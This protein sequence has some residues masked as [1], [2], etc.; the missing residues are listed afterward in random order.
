M[1]LSEV[2]I[3]ENIMTIR[4]ENEKILQPRLRSTTLQKLR[5]CER[6]LADEKAKEQ[7]LR[8]AIDSVAKDLEK[9]EA[10][11]QECKK[12]LNNDRRKMER[13]NHQEGIR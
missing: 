13:Q 7:P 9:C 3:G 6:E 2:T 10:M 12:W 1:S 4:K 11:L 8:D 5:D